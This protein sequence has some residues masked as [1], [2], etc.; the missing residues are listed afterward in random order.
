MRQ[1][2]SWILAFVFPPKLDRLYLEHLR[3]TISYQNRIT[4]RGIDRPVDCKLTGAWVEGKAKERR[5]LLM[6]PRQWT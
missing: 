4:R 5:L 6:A 3:D 2:I 1:A